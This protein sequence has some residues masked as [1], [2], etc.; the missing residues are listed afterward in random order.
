MVKGRN[1]L[2]VRG[3]TVAYSPSQEADATGAPIEPN[4]TH[5]IF[6]NNPN[7]G[8]GGEIMVCGGGVFLMIFF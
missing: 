8:W 5:F 7:Q 1:V 4:H 3:T 6:V 2:G